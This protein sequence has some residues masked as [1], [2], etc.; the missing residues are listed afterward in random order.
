MKPDAPLLPRAWL[1]VG[2]LWCEACVN[3]VA[4][5]MITTMHGSLVA[6]IPMS[7]AQFGLLTSAF[8]CVYGAMSPF[9][10]F[11]SDR[12]GRTRVILTALL[13]WSVITWLTS[14]AV[15]YPQLL[16]M[17]I[18]MALAEVCYMPAAVSLI[19]DYH[20]GP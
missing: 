18:L 19:A 17:R 15:S 11:L 4:R 1:T 16:V 13:T 12:F 14:Y 2:R 8:M 3:L 20:R 10:G 9:A 5:N 7:E 6:A